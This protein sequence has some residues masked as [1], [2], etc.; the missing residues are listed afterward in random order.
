MPATPAVV[1]RQDQTLTFALSTHPDI[2]VHTDC[3]EAGYVHTGV[4]D[5]LGQQA[6]RK[7]H[8]TAL[9]VS[10]LVS[11]ERLQLVTFVG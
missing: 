9:Q 8:H 4:I 11:H 3:S 10:L 6:L 7:T 1:Y 2:P 5:A